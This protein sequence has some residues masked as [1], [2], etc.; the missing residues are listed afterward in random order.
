ME[1]KRA[2]W[3][4]FYALKLCSHSKKDSFLT[5]GN[6][7]RAKGSISKGCCRVV[8]ATPLFGTGM[9]QQ[10]FHLPSDLTLSLTAESWDQSW[11]DRT[12]EWIS[13]ALE[14]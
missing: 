9:E 13:A 5:E 8:T 1:S 12:E 7:K 2:S 14:T 3:Q 10:L 6:W 11:G 4:V